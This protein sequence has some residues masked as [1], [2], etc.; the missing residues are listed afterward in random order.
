MSMLSRYKK[1]G[2][3]LQLLKL[4]ETTGQNKREKF[5]EIIEEENKHWAVAIKSK[6]LNIELI[7]SWEANILREISGR[8]KPIVLATA[9]HGLEG[10][11]KE[12]L[13]NTFSQ[14]LKRQVDNLININEPTK[15]EISATFVLIIEEV[16]SMVKQGYIRFENIQSELVIE[17][18]IE[19]KLDKLMDGM[20]YFTSSSP[21]DKNVSVDPNHSD[22]F[23]NNENL[24]I[25]VNQ[26]DFSKLKS[27]L[28][29]LNKEN[30]NLKKENSNL[31]EKLEKI[32]KIA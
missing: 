1:A 26:I 8:L 11:L 12:N 13:L 23:G 15:A 31:K 24:D 4:V 22:K 28:I 29:D 21:D 19:E 32:K 6:M 5:L 17:D 18:D 20:D 25:P 30:L 2:G 3:F 16:R 10:E 27:K 9:L 7:L 14:T